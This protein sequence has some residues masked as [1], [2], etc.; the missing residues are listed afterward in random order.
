MRFSTDG[1]LTQASFLRDYWQKK[2]CLIRQAFPNFQPL[3]DANDVAGLACEEMAEARLIS[4]SFKKQ[5]W[6][7]RHGP[8]TERSLRRLPETEWTLLVQDVE[9]HYP[10]L[11]S[12]LEEF[13][14]LPSWRMDDL[15]ISVAAPGGSVGPHVDQYDVFLLQAAGKRRWRIAE[16]FEPGLLPGCELK[17]LRNFQA[18]HEWDLE[19]GDVLY[20]PPNVA[21]HG[22]ALEDCMT[23]SI[24]LRAPSQAELLLAFGDWISDEW[25]EG[26]RY[27]DGK[28]R[29]ASRPGELSHSACRRLGKLLHSPLPSANAV[30]GFFASF[31]SRY[32]LAHEPAAPQKSWNKRE[33]AAAIRKSATLHRNPWTRLVWVEQDGRARLFAAG[34]EFDCPVETAVRVCSAASE[35]PVDHTCDSETL[36]VLRKLVNSGH[37]VLGF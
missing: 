25:Q 5:N 14:F 26:P 19:A 8:F 6:S 7:V 2:P 10:P 36:D 32:R 27:S 18:E 9:K 13:A 28:M 21:H 16:S 30:E 20:L 24:G 17:V 11:Q 35:V 29:G 23:W 4:G 34:E 37:I 1:N 15:M 31:L 12:L 33:F 3:L 22:I